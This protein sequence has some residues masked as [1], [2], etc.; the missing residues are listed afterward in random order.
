MKILMISDLHISSKS[1]VERANNIISHM[2][3]K[4]NELLIPNESLLVL[5]LGDL[6]DFYCYETENGCYHA[7]SVLQNLVQ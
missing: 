1:D 5:N 6:A 2:K 3:S 7:E 4:L